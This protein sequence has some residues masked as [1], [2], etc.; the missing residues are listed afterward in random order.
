MLGIIEVLLFSSF[1][2]L[3]NLLLSDENPLSMPAPVVQSLSDAPAVE[4]IHPPTSPWFQTGE[5]NLSK[6]TL[7]KIRFV[8][9]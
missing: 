1:F 9:N 5:Y 8:A 7:C 3:E 4:F 6:G 2:G